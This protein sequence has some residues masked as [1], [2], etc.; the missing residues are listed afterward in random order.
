MFFIIYLRPPSYN[1]IVFLH[2][3][4]VRVS[5]SDLPALVLFPAL[6]AEHHIKPVTTVAITWNTGFN[7]L[8]F[9]GTFHIPY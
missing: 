9:V 5:I 3:L 4:R 2:D 6:V 7:F 8:S 1:G